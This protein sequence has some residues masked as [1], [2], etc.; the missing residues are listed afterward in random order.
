MPWSNFPD[1]FADGVSVRGIPILQSQPGEVFYV[2]NGPILRP[3]AVPGTDSGSRGTFLDPFA[4][5][6]YAVNTRCGPGRGDI[7]FVMPNHRETISNATT[8]LLQCSGVAVVG[9][10]AGNTRPT[11]VF[12][13]A[14]AAGIPL[15]GANISIQNC[16][17]VGNFAD[18]AS[19]V[20]ANSGSVTA[21]ITGDVM[22]V[23][24]S[25]SGT[26]A[27]GL[28]LVSSIVTVGTVITEQISGT[29]GGVGTYRVTP[30]QTAV[31]GTITTA[32]TDFAFVGNEIR[33][34][35]S[36]LNALSVLKTSSVD[37]AS[38]G[39]IFS[40]N[41]VSSLGTTAATTAVVLAGAVDRMTM[42][43][44]F[45]CWAI[46]D[47]T[48][49]ILECASKNLTNFEFSRNKLFRP[50]DSTTGGGFIGSPGTSCTGMCVENY[51]W[52]LDGSSGI[53]IKTS[54]DLGFAENFSPVTG[55]ADI[56][57]T[58]NPTRA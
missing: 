45:G 52:H 31:S 39:L 33:D 47:N 43:D 37:N 3:N 16:I 2:G 56:N 14:T 51:M 27:R 26:L 28:T 25:G 20:T 8:L 21:T 11:F 42:N 44:N 18:V 7:V 24:S 53:W 29:T 40:G 13:T 6:T 57:A 5:L 38:D 48:P 36:I 49:A 50:L 32:T 9:I 58:I 17:F 4:T 55:A 12:D 10:G 1:G 15:W 30:S 34:T 41:R 54:S 35:S 23:T 22:D 19:M 46:V